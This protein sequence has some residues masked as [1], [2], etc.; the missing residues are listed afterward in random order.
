MSSSEDS[1]SDFEGVYSSGGEEGTE[2]KMKRLTRLRGTRKKSR[3]LDMDEAAVDEHTGLSPRMTRMDIVSRPSYQVSNDVY[4]LDEGVE[5]FSVDCEDPRTNSVREIYNELERRLNLA[6]AHAGLHAYDPAVSCLK[7]KLASR[8]AEIEAKIAD[9]LGSSSPTY[10]QALFGILRWL[11]TATENELR[12]VF[13]GHAA[14]VL[15]I[16][17]GQ[18]DL[19]ASTRQLCIMNELLL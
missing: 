8:A 18:H 7:T 14:P 10:T 17:D 13:E 3:S 2:R 5:T 11:Q 19:S 16:E 12:D 9:S 6:A 1:D 4:F 15:S